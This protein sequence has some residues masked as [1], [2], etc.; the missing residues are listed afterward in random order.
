LFATTA[1]RLARHLIWKV[2]WED[3][4]NMMLDVILP[5]GA[6]VPIVVILASGH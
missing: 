1:A 5:P 3:R 4:L 6:L 2:P